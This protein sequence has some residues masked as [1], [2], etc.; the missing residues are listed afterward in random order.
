ETARLYQELSFSLARTG[1]AGKAAVVLER[2]RARTL[3]RLLA[4]G[5]GALDELARDRPDLAERVRR[6]L[7]DV[8]RIE[9]AERRIA[10]LPAV[11]AQRLRVRART[12]RIVLEQELTDVRELPEHRHFFDDD[13]DSAGTPWG[14]GTLYVS[15][16]AAGGSA[17]FAGEDGVE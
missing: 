15:A 3:T 12:A 2:S 7:D 5:A 16:T 13:G 10:S 14:Q 8:R 9:E 17:L 11:D 1:A 6:A 4:R